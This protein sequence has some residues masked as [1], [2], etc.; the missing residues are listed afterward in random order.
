MKLKLKQDLSFLVL[1]S[2]FFYV[3]SPYIPLIADGI[4]HTFWEKEH[5]QSA[6]HTYGN[7]HVGLE[8]IKAEKQS[9]KEDTTNNQKTGQED[10][11]HTTSLHVQLEFPAGQVIDRVYAL[12][13]AATLSSFLDIDYPPPRL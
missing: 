9:G 10:L 3:F 11:S 13:N 5:L 2:Y 1:F 4:A 6:H 12:F 7:N 8:I